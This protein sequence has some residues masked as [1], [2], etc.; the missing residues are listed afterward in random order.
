[1]ERLA[2]KLDKRWVQLGDIISD[3]KAA[4]KIFKK[5]KKRR[6]VEVV[7]IGILEAETAREAIADAL[8]ELEKILS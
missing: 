1:M 8:D 4:E 2:K 5:L 3:M 7:H 6:A